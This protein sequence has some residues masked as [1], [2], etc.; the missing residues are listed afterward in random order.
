MANFKDYG[1][2][3]T[4]YLSRNS[5]T[6]TMKGAF[7]AFVIGLVLLLAIYFKLRV[8]RSKSSFDIHI[9]DT[10][11]V[12]QYS[13]AVV[14]ALLVLGFFFSIGGVI[15]TYFKSKLF[16]V[17]ATLFSLLL[18]YIAV[19]FYISYRNSGETSIPEG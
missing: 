5:Q 17:L 13:H 4:G 3:S 2:A 15:G 7:I 9:R 12:I 19:P 10:F 11:Y 8:Y 18:T 6:V 14:A 1:I 16:L